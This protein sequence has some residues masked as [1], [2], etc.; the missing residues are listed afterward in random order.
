MSVDLCSLWPHF[1]Q[2]LKVSLADFNH[3]INFR[4]TFDQ[5][6]WHDFI[7]DDG[8]RSY[9]FDCYYFFTSYDF[10]PWDNLLSELANPKENLSACLQQQESGRYF[11]SWID[12]PNQ[13]SIIFVENCCLMSTCFWSRTSVIWIIVY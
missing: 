10:I 8:K 5:F 6:F 7:W 13:S 1:G 4:S 11:P 12:Y 9:G 2:I 3:F